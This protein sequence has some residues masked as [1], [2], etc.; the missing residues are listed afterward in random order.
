MIAK[1]TN[2]GSSF[3]GAF[4]YYLHDKGTQTRERVDWTHT[5]NLLTDDPDK[6]WKVMAYTAREAGRLKEASG[7]RAS[8]RKL[9]KPVFAYSLAWHPEQ[10]PDRDQM[11]E[12][13]R[14]SIR[15]LGLEEHETLIVAHRDEPQ[16]HV[17][18]VINRVHPLTGIAASTGRSKL[19]L[20]EFALAYERE[21]GKIYCQQREQNHRKRQKG[22]RTMFRDAV[23]NDAWHG[24]DSGR[25][26]I[27]ALA[28][29][30]YILARGRKRIV[31]VDPHGKVHNPARHIEEATAKDIRERLKDVDPTELPDADE[32]S[33]R[34]QAQGKER[35]DER[36]RKERASAEA[37]NQ[38]Q[39]SHHEERAQVFNRHHDR[40]EAER[41]R[42]T[43]Y[44]KLEE[45][46][47]QV[48]ALKKK[49]ARPG[50]WRKLL[51]FDR[52]DR[53]RL[54]ELTRNYD[55]ATNRVN[56]RVQFLEKDRDQAL[57]TLAERQA[58]ERQLLMEHGP[59]ALDAWRNRNRVVE[60]SVSVEHDIHGPRLR[61]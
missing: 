5:E 23:I 11:L 48:T 39:S 13:A 60:K 37:Q 56:E 4:L 33:H 1:V 58:R 46:H 20:S 29:K 47:A 3:K 54:D 50:W 2:G 24:S 10:N 35:Y 18:V 34:I 40:I 7:Q 6:A 61:R 41:T 14:K 32:V 51:G 28:D 22:E 30:D 8:G 59:E 57:R 31:V 38:L 26:F 15:Y 12:A 19:R 44:Y 25:G 21:H 49:T 36:Q 52:Q 45:Q 17:H 43:E 42:L 9:E 55:D 27:A 53:V 16:K